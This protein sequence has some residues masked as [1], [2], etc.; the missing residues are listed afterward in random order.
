ME[1]LAPFITIHNLLLLSS[2]LRRFLSELAEPEM[3]SLPQ[4]RENYSSAWPRTTQN[5]SGEVRKTHIR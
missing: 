5:L 4:G 1:V 3:E 2:R